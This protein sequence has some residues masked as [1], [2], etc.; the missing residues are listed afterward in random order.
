MNV[1]LILWIVTSVVLLP[2]FGDEILPVFSPAYSFSIDTTGEASVVKTLEPIE[3]KYNVA[4]TIDATCE[5][6]GI[7]ENILEKSQDLGV[8]A[9]TPSCGGKW[10][11][12]NSVEGVAVFYVRHSLFP[13]KWG[14][15]TEADPV[16]IIDN[17]E[18][19]EMVESGAAAE[20]FVFS[21]GGLGFIGSLMLPADTVLEEIANGT[22]RIVSADSGFLFKSRPKPF[23]ID[24]FRPGPNR[25][26]RFGEMM[27]LAYTGDNWIGAHDASSVLELVSPSGTKSQM[28]FAGT[29]VYEFCPQERGVWELKLKN[30]FGLYSGNIS[31]L[32]DSVIMSVR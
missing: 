4:Q 32:Y 19:V 23:V 20:G 10:V 26:W 27:S 11:L 29:G 5:D 8:S 30:V 17:D 2:I 22:Y 21:L 31:V 24:T 1:K 3:L 18:I 16:E 25:R 13:G 9:W 15:G 12:T 7:S 6:H 14:A 28:E